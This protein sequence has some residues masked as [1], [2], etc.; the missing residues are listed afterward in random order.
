MTL[1]VGE[2]TFQA[3]AS[4]PQGEERDRIFAEFFER[5]PGFGEYQK[6]TSRQIPV[7]LLERIED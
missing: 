4:V 2:E 1:E 6:S 7:V 5:M 3:R